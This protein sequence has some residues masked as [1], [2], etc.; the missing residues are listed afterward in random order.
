VV[1]APRAD[2]LARRDRARDKTGYGVWTADSLDHAL[3]HETPRLGLWLDTSDQTP[4]ETVAAIR[5]YLTS[6]RLPD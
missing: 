1:L 5:A 4:D 3:R 2:V 6:A